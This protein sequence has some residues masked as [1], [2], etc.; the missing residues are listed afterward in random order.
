MGAYG[1][2]VT[3]NYNSKIRAWY[4]IK[5]IKMEC[6]GS[7][8]IVYQMSHTVGWSSNPYLIDVETKN[9]IQVNDYCIY[10]IM[11][12]YYKWGG[13]TSKDYR[14]KFQEHNSFVSPNMTRM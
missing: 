11:D 1:Y 9:E 8:R 7:S 2:K 14:S 10:T 5:K 13:H 3:T 12:R 4:P 6:N